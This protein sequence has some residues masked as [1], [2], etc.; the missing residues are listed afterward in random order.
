MVKTFP[1]SILPLVILLFLWGCASLVSQKRPQIEV[2]NRYSPEQLKEDLDFWFKTCE[3]VH[4]DLYL[5]TPED[6]IDSMIVSVMNKLNHPMTA[7]EFWKLLA[8]VVAKL[9]DGH[10][11]L[12]FPYSFRRKYLDAGGTIFPLDVRIDGEQLLVRENYSSDSTLAVNSE[13]LSING[14]PQE[15]ILQDLRRYRGGETVGLVNRYVQRMFKPLLWAHYVFEDRFEVEYISSLDGE[16]YSETLTGVRSEEYDSLSQKKDKSKQA[17]TYWTF[18]SIPDEK[19][20]ILDLNSFAWPRDLKSFQKF[21]KSTFTTIRDEG[22]SNLIIDLRRNGGGDNTLGEALIDYLATQPW[23]LMSKAEVRLSPQMKRDLI[24]WFLRWMPIK[25]AIKAFAF[26]YSSQGI[27]RVEI[28]SDSN[29]V[30]LLTVYT[31]PKKLKKNALR[32]SGKTFVLIDNGSYSMSVIFAAVMKDYGFATLIGEET[33]QSANPYGG[34][35][36][37]SLPNT[38]LRAS[39]SMGR[40]FRP[41]GEDTGRGVIPEYEVQQNSEDLEKGFDTVVEFTKQLIREN[42]KNTGKAG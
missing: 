15:M 17:P 7:L 4:P 29:N 12:N 41:S 25:P 11:F 18:Q 32:F 5:Y 37:F 27:E 21:L 14:L 33:G 8:P 36:F 28:F 42:A 22:L 24:P 38:H 3:D 19:I 35:Y 26:L 39:V 6:V 1:K 30:D 40:T 9:G 2:G 16:H 34:N 23:V 20:G 13:I 10:T 31:E